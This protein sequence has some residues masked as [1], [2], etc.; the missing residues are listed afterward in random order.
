MPYSRKPVIVDVNKTFNEWRIEI[1]AA[2]TK[3]NELFDTSNEFHPAPGAL[4]DAVTVSGSTITESTFQEGAIDNSTLSVVTIENSTWNNGVIDGATV[5]NAVFESSNTIQGNLTNP[6]IT[7]P[8][9]SGGTWGNGAAT[10]LTLQE[11]SLGGFEP[12]EEVTVTVASHTAG[13]STVT[14]TTVPKDLT[15]AKFWYEGKEYTVLSSNSGASTMEVAE[16]EPTTQFSGDLLLKFGIRS[17]LESP[18]VTEPLFSG[19]VHMDGD[20]IYMIVK[21]GDSAKRIALAEGTPFELYFD[22][23]LRTVHLFNGT[24]VGGEVVKALPYH[25]SGVSL[26]GDPYFGEEFYIP[27]SGHW[28]KYNGSIWQQITA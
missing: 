26:P 11:I 2:I 21:H 7:N 9:I 14:L 13:S 25:E 10:G 12:T 5:R 6:T 8:T 16:V 28:F 20:D 4:F 24:D 15:N 18:K 22:T 17:L 27:A 19:V 3:L 1:N 23:D